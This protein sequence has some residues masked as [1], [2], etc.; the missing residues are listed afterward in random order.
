MDLFGDLPEPANEIMQAKPV[1]C[2]DSN[3]EL[4]NTSND[5]DKDKRKRTNSEVGNAVNTNA[6]RPAI[7][8]F[9]MRGYSAERK[10]EREEMQDAHVVID[11]FLPE[12]DKPPS[13]LLNLSY[14]AV[15]DGHGGLRASSY[16]AQKL[17]KIIAQKFPK[18][19]AGIEVDMKRCFT[20][21]FKKLDEDFLTEA[22]QKK[23]SWKDGTTA[24]SVLAVNNTLYIGN[25]GDSKAVLCRFN[26]STKNH[27]AIPLTVDH[28]PTLYEERMR[29]QKAGGH[30][31]EGR[32][33]GVLEVSRSIGDGPFKKHGVSCIP[34][35]K[36]CQL[37]Q[38]D[39][40][41]LI[42]C[43]GLWKRFDNDTAIDFI[44]SIL[45]DDRIKATETKDA[46]EIRWETA[47]TR[48]ANEAVRRL[49]ADNVTVILV[50]IAY[51]RQDA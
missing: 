40:F 46:N 14:Y 26:E 5:F 20:E 37:Q 25:L 10:G 44:N 18:G 43:D 33:M 3:V 50:A 41:V 39:K 19:M 38:N 31:R 32:V 2:T 45:S 36:R 22:R 16:S 28:N 23:P 35:V 6:K 34:D 42:A 48:L 12:V 30:V 1:S 21:S 24:V 47:C 51:Q 11:E 15:F 49:S 27:V 29:I 7:G 8:V 9:K 4:P 13:D 17:H